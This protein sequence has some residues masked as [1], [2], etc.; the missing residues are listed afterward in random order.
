MNFQQFAK[1]LCTGNGALLSTETH[2]SITWDP[3]LNPQHTVALGLAGVSQGSR[4]MTV[5]IDAA[6]PSAGPE[7]DPVP[8]AGTAE[9]VE[10]GLII[11]GSGKQCTTKGFITKASMDHGVNA[12]AKLTFSLIGAWAEFE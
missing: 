3:A 10:L 1:I 2:V 12:E 5:D 4:Y 6:V 8:L 9:I 11:P 7:F